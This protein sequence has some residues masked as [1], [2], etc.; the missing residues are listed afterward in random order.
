MLRQFIPD[1]SRRRRESTTTDLRAELH[2]ALQTGRLRD[3]LSV[4]ELI[5]K[6]KPDE[7]RWARRK[8][9]LLYRMGRHTDAVI[10]YERAV[11]LYAAKGFDARA[12]ATAKVML[13][14]DPSKDQV[15]ERLSRPP[16]LQPFRV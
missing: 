9:D 2:K 3:A 11:D 12:I 4:C 1:K 7:P 10:A 6:R 8:A 15:L 14:I 16:P 5:E 13:A